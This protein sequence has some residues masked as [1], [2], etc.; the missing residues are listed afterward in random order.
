MYSK[1]FERLLTHWLRDKH[2]VIECSLIIIASLIV[3]D[4]L[5]EVFERVFYSFS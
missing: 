4:E 2:E 5:Q 1:Q 3:T